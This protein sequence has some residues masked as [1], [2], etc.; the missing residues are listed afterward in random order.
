M[1]FKYN[2]RKRLI[3]TG[4]GFLIFA[5]LNLG[6]FVFTIFMNSLQNEITIF[7]NVVCLAIGVIT[8]I[9]YVQLPKKDYIRIDDNAISVHTGPGKTRKR[10]L[11]DSI[12][13]VV[14]VSNIIEIKLNNK[15]EQIVYL[16]SLAEDDVKELKERLKQ[17][18]EWRNTHVN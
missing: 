4:V 15:K 18:A 17:K 13:M 6:V 10:I 12:K 3:R 11:F 1:G 8:G 7:I 14:E 16:S 9:H 2:N 5:L